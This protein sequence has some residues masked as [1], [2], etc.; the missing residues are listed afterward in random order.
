MTYMTTEDKAKFVID[1]V[2]YGLSPLRH[3]LYRAWRLKKELTERITDHFHRGSML[4]TI[5]NKPKNVESPA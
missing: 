3:C 1:G 5:D 2:E 4:R